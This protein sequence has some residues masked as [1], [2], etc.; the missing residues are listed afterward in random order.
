M[1]ASALVPVGAIQPD[2]RVLCS[3][4]T[5]FS[6]SANAVIGAE[7]RKPLHRYAE[8]GDG[9]SAETNRSG[10]GRGR[11]AGMLG[12]LLVEMPDGRRFRLGTGFSDA[13]C[14][15][16]PPIGATVTYRYYGTTRNGIPRFASFL[17][18]RPPE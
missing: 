8:I 18:V 12:A 17:R 2:T 15:R 4:S 14:R 6:N 13:E 11:Y 5:A 10:L 9:A 7:H 16:P 1:Y 3:H